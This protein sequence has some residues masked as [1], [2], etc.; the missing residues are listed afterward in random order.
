[1]FFNKLI[2]VCFICGFVCAKHWIRETIMPI[3]LT[4]DEEQC[5]KSIFDNP[6]D[7][8]AG[9]E[10]KAKQKWHIGGNQTLKDFCCGAWNVIPCVLREG[11]S[12]C[13]QFYVKFHQELMK[14]IHDIEKDSCFGNLKFNGTAC[15]N[16][17]TKH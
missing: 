9:C 3:S 14:L 1:M 15:F 2:L 4:D 5:L 17:N 13:P 12:V 8:F 11:L 16:S 6:S 7:E 10:C